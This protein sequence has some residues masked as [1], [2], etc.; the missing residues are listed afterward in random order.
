MVSEVLKDVTADMQKCVD[1]LVHELASVRSGRASPALV[2]G[3]MVEYHDVTLPIKQLA[4][5]AV[6]EPTL[7]TIQAWDKTANRAIEKGI[8]K[9]NLGLNP[10]NDGNVIRLAI[11]PLNEERRVEL[12]KLVGKRVEERKVAL[13]NIRRDHVAH[14]KQ[15]EKDKLVSEDEMASTL[16]KIDELSDV[17]IEKAAEIGR[18]KERE[19][20]EL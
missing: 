20:K 10:S 7:I 19:I 8:L 9:A 5:I 18:G 4:N 15:M 17:F 11:P 3:V 6:P 16:K 12:A 1:G 14:L 13:R 2:E